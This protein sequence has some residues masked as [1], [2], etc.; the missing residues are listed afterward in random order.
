MKSQDQIHASNL[1][2]LL[3]RCSTIEEALEEV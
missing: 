3:P 2:L 1:S